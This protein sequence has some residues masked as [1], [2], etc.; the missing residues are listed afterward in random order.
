MY[1]AT[2]WKLPADAC[3]LGEG[4]HFDRETDTA[5]WFDIVG[6]NLIEHRFP[7]N[8]SLVHELPRM[9]SV[10]ARVDAG[11][12]LL[13]MENGLYLRTKSDGQ[14]RLLAPLEAENAATR[15]NDG[16]VHPSGNLWIGTMGK[17]AEAGA[18]SIYWFD[19]HE[20]RR[21]YARISIPNSICF[22]P[23]GA[24][25]YFADT[26]VN[27]IW[28]VALDPATGLPTSEPEVALT[29]K[30]LPLG[31]HFDGSVIDTDGVLWNAAYGGG[32]VSGFAPDG[33]LVQTFE[34]PATQTTCPCFV[35][36]ELDKLLVTSAWQGYSTTERAADPGAGFTY[37]IDG[38]FKGQ[39]DP[40]FDLKID[41]IQLI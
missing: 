31:G 16:R 37:V 41:D 13:A 15:S 7:E 1:K 18:G 4:P 6:Q 14:L 21:L 19:G 24:S 33:S 35:G 27:T 3:E 34:V 12:Q 22:S 20:I 9:A 25:G 23:D 5:W 30:D 29:E 39:A 17:N 8:L 32:S 2:T 40:A 11:H 26:G 28:R 10:I 36:A 38:K